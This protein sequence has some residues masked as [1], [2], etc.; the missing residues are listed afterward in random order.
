MIK[1]SVEFGIMD[2]K[3]QTLDTT[4]RDGAQSVAVSFSVDDKIRIVK[5]LDELGIDLIEAG[6]PS[7]NVKD[8]VFFSE[9]ASVKLNHSKLVAFGSTRRVGVK[10]EDDQMTAALLSAGTEYVTIFG[11]S[12][13]L[14][15]TD[16]LKT[17][18]EENLAM[19]KETTEYLVSHGRRVIFDAEHY[20]DGYKRNPEY[21]IKVI[22]TA[23]AAGCEAVCLCDTNGGCFPDEIYDITKAACEAVDCPVG[24]HAHND[25]G[26]AVSNSI[27]AVKAGAE[28]VQGTLNGIGERCGNA[29]LGTIMA[30]LQLKRGYDVIGEENMRR[31]T[32]ISRTVAEISNIGISGMPYVSK[33]AFSHKAGMHIDGVKKRSESFEHVEPARVGNE[34]TFM[35]SEVAGKSAVLPLIQKVDPTADKNSPMIKPVMDAL[36]ELEFEGYQFEAAEASLYIVITNVLGL[37]KTFFEIERFRIMIE[38]D[39]LPEVGEEDYSSAIVKVKVGDEYEITAAD[40]SSGPVNAI[41][42]ALR[43]SLERFYPSLKDMRLVDYKV[44]V[45]DSAAATGAKV[46]VLV[47]STDGGDRLNIF[48][49]SMEVI[50]A[51]R[52]AI[53][54][55]IIYKLIKDEK[56]G[57]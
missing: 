25:S 41:D 31:L 14:H 1:F 40:S 45:L 54:D 37:N 33:N 49:V 19:I 46:R 52:M 4:L 38:Q 23:C 3:I 5:L 24:V 6:N 29:N 7:S 53:V 9:M 15:V 16:I 27:M 28:H 42:I 30:N 55:S 56:N 57:K 48:G 36:K 20:Y 47:E 17:T 2:K 13:D 34:R 11:K 35:V 43:K 26:M 51:S 32:E 10:V 21:A 12:W 39:R 8:A 44:R 18:L 50:F 22:K